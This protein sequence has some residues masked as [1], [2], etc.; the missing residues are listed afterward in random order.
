[1]VHA[2]VRPGFNLLMISVSDA[3]KIFF[4]CMYKSN[5]T[6]TGDISHAYDGAVEQD[7][8]R[9]VTVEYSVKPVNK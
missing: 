3:L 5:H 1:M 2:T 7:I 6:Y 9:P 4:M 8:V